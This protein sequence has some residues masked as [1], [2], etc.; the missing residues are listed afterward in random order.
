MEVLKFDDYNEVTSK[1]SDWLGLSVQEN[2]CFALFKVNGS[3]ILNREVSVHGKFKPW[4][5]GNY[6]SHVK[7]SAAQV[8]L[9]IGVLEC[10]G[11]L[12]LY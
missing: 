1:I 8:K 9:G 4:L 6:L 10:G 7:K 11:L 5:I 3:R 2:E 12:V